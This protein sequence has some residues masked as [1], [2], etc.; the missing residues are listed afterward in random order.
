MWA[1]LAPSSVSFGVLNYTASRPYYTEAHHPDVN[2]RFT[3]G[4]EAFIILA[5][6]AG[7]TDPL[8]S[9]FDDPAPPP[10]TGRLEPRRVR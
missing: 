10:L 1:A 3:H 8:A 5:H 7:L 9:P 2:P 6:P 4:T